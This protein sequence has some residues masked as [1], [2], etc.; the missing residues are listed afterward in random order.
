MTIT[1]LGASGH[2]GGETA[3]LLLDRGEPVRAV[4]RSA[5][6]LAR[7]ER[8]G[9]EPLVGDVADAEF[10]RRAFIGA[11]AALTMLPYGPDTRDY[12]AEQRAKG[13]AITAALR[14]AGTPRV[15]FVSSLG[16]D[17]PSGTGAIESLHEQEQRLGMLPI[18][19][20]ILRSGSF[21]ENFLPAVEVIQKHG[22]NVDAMDPDVSVPMIATRD[23]AAVAADALATGGW[24]GTVIRELQ[25]ERDLTWREATSILGEALGHPELEYVQL[26]YE[27]M[28]AM[29]A[30]AGFSP[31]VARMTVEV[32]RALNEGRIRWEPRR[33]GNSTTTP[34]EE[35][36]GAL[37]E[38]FH[39]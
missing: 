8:A 18:G 20:M 5:E 39:G 33:P 38:V 29:L 12:M 9:A 13:E 36:A 3:R 28:C 2:I 15:V 21:F 16:A 37:Q 6:K 25:G 1:I 34:F 32:A 4:G 35:F 24:T 10:L 19:L 14:D 17:L 27:E 30:Q 7:L 11:E 26:P 31:D 23:I 22:V